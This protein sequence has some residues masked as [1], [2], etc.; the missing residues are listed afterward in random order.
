MRLDDGIS[1][2]IERHGADGRLGAPAGGPD[3]AS[4]HQRPKVCTDTPTS[5]ATAPALALSGGSNR[6]TALFL[7]ASPYPAMFRPYRPRAQDYNGAT[8]I[9]TRAEGGT[10]LMNSES[11]CWYFIWSRGFLGSILLRRRP[12]EREHC[13]AVCPPPQEIYTLTHHA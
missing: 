12:L 4:S 13:S 10:F 7:N 2:W 1:F 3:C 11:V 5:L 8:T 6:A 9:L